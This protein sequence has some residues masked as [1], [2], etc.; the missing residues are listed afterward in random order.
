M[1]FLVGIIMLTGCGKKNDS[2]KL[3]D[4]L[5]EL[6]NAYYKK[7]YNLIEEEKRKDFLSKYTTLGIKVDLENLARTVA[8]SDGF[9]S[10]DELIEEFTKDGKSCNLTT[11]K[12]VLYP[13]EPYGESDFKMDINLNCEESKK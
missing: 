10:K 3:N 5:N 2:E 9:P 1:S 11:S 13:Q 12:L 4:R 7:Y 8:D 6:G